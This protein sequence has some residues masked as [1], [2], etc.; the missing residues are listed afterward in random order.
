MAVSLV[1]WLGAVWTTS[2]LAFQEFSGFQQ[3]HSEECFAG[4]VRW[5]VLDMGPCRSGYR[6]VSEVF[7]VLTGS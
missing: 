3:S 5:L 6:V 1:H 4:P 2:V 7:P